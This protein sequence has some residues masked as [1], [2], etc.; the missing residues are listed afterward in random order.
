MYIS[1]DVEYDIAV[2]YRVLVCCD[3]CSNRRANLSSGRH[4]QVGNNGALAS[5]SAAAGVTTGSTMSSP[6]GPGSEAE[7]YA[8]RAGAGTETP[9][10]AGALAGAEAG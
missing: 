7:A 4:R 6:G 9:S 8:G 10:A 1:F 3:D 5:A 2:R